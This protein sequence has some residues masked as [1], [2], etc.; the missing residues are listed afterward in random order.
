[1]TLLILRNMIAR[2][3]TKYEHG[4]AS[5]IPTTR[6]VPMQVQIFYIRFMPATKTLVNAVTGGALVNKTKE[7]AAHNLLEKM[8]LNNDHSG[9]ERNILRR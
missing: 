4:L 9:V 7:A 6:A 2:R 5:K 1:M 8:A 3:S